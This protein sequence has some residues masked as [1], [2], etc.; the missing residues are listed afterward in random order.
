[1]HHNNYILGFV[2]YATYIC[3]AFFF[4]FF[5]PVFICYAFPYEWFFA[6]FF[7]LGS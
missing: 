6:Y 3:D 4:F 5:L 1:M 7:L 2:F